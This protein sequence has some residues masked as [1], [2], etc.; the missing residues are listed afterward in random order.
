MAYPGQQPGGYGQ[1]GYGQQPGYG[2]ADPLYDYYQRV[3][4]P[5]QQIDSREL[6]Q[7]LAQS[8]ISGSYQMFRGTKRLIAMCDR[9]RSGKMDFNEFKEMWNI[10]HQWKNT[11]M[12]YDRDRSGTIDP[13]EMHT[14]L[15]S[16]GYR[17]SPQALNIIIATSGDDGRI[18]FDGFVGA[19]IA[20]RTLSD[21]FRRRDVQQNG[22]AMFTYDDF[23][24][25]TFS[26]MG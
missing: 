13:Q 17:L 19:A 12:Q 15:Q 14:A 7:L 26:A 1:P 8:G 2:A 21:Q 6:E 16:F 22:Q 4:G 5:D 25:V 18:T 23:I 9:N 11:F 3:A 10:L 24:Q 20:L